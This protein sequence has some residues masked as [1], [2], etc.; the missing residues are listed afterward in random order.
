MN[1][2]VLKDPYADTKKR[3]TTKFHEVIAA[4]LGN[5]FEW[6]DFII[7]GYFATLL[8]KLFFPAGDEFTSLLLV[9]ATFGLGFVVRPVGSIV[10]G[11]YSDRYGRKQSMIVTIWLMVI[12]TAAIGFAP[13]YTTAGW[14]GAVMIVVARLLQG[15]ASSGEYGSAIAFLVE[16]AP[17]NRKNLYA[18]FQVAST[19]LAIVM[20]GIIGSMMTL[21]LSP[22]T[23][24]SWGWRVPFLLGLL[25]GPIGY[26]IRRNVDETKEFV[27]S[28]RLS[29]KAALASVFGEHL[30]TTTGALMI[31]TAGTVTFYLL[32][33]YMPTFASRELGISG[34]VKFASSAL[35]GFVM[36][37]ISPIIGYLADRFFKPTAVM[38]SGM[39]LLAILAFPLFAWIIENP[40]GEKLI[41]L[42]VL[43][44]MPLAIITGLSG[45]IVA[46]LYPTEVRTTGLSFAY[47]IPPTFFGGLSPLVVSYLIAT[48]GNKASPALYIILVA[49]IGLCGAL[50]VRAK[51]PITVKA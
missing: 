20:A 10:F 14:T 49:V 35:G 8:A 1:S 33:V 2:R 41:I 30:R 22:E 16:K 47:N 29:A 51:K 36:I 42:T 18:S 45:A 37:I 12:G 5:A 24:E 26:Y 39:V 13:V 9:L 15:F 19:M 6:F 38:A 28:K 25:I 31:N 7:Y 46:Q 23:L 21:Y 27:D 43:L 32:L 17:Q 11:L 3:T 40:T 48:T 4:S 50:L 34:E 44:S